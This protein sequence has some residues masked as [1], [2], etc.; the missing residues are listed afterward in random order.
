MA[1]KSLPR[2]K[3]TDVLLDFSAYSAATYIASL[4]ESIV[5]RE[6]SNNTITA[7]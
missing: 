3:L 5:E 4:K 6:C 2:C 1:Q 7:T